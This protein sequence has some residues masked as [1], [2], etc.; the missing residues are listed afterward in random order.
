QSTPS[1]GAHAKRSVLRVAITAAVAPPATTAPT[2]AQ[3]QNDSKTL[4]LSTSDNEIDDSSPARTSASTSASS[5]PSSA[6]RTRYRPGE[7]TNECDPR[8]AE[9]STAPPATVRRYKGARS[10]VTR[11]ISW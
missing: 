6:A 4:R 1:N 2:I 3:N 10:G 8:A 7:T 5:K 9:S 11:T